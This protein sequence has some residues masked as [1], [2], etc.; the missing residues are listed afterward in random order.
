MTA[1]GANSQTITARTTRYKADGTKQVTV[2]MPAAYESTYL[3]TLSLGD[4]DGDL[5]LGEYS[6]SVTKGKCTVTLTYV[7]ASEYTRSFGGTGDPVL[8][9]DTN[10]TERPIELHPL[11]SGGLSELG[12]VP[13]VNGNEKPGVQSYLVPMTTYRRTTVETS[14]TWSEE[15][16]TLGVGLCSA[17]TGLSGA[18]STKWLKVARIPTEDGD[19]VRL[20]EIWQYNPDHWDVDIYEDGL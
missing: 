14:F 15:N 8:E 5:V 10:A 3:D 12:G 18:T 4:A 2:E 9:G 19:N 11:Y 20:V 13:N 16:L 1:F 6:S 7:T 17:P